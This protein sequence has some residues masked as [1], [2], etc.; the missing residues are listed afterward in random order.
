MQVEDEGGQGGDPFEMEDLR[1]QLDR[2]EA[3]D[4]M[5]ALQAQLQALTNQ[6]A[7][8]RAPAV[9]EVPE[10]VLDVLPAEQ[11]IAA[12]AVTQT[13]MAVTRASIASL[14]V[15]GGPPQD[16]DAWI[17]SLEAVADQG[18]L[19]DVK[20]VRLATSKFGPMLLTWLRI[21]RREEGAG[22]AWIV[23]RE[24]MRGEHGKTFVKKAWAEEVVKARQKLD[25]EFE[26]YHRRMVMLLAE[27]PGLS[28][29]ERTEEMIDGLRNPSLRGSLR[30]ARRGSL[31]AGV[32]GVRRLVRD[33]PAM[34]RSQHG[35]RTGT[36]PKLGA[37]GGSQKSVDGGG[38]SGA[39]KD[40]CFYCQQPGHFAKEC[41]K[42]KQ[43]S[44]QGNAY[45]ESLPHV[46]P[47]DDGDE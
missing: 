9:Q 3:R 6:L 45:V 31:A 36:A 35:G 20:R 16:L 39:R 37:G 23:L 2:E 21:V 14:A 8:V 34:V 46:S 28:A 11:P 26:P 25:K 29:E 40:V 47:Q 7:A 44:A 27:N 38:P 13:Q 1:L 22:F 12:A 17:D 30:Q 41:P 32:E 10:P 19:G 4:L 42:K 18:V 33:F 43:K 15:Y 5:V 24:Q